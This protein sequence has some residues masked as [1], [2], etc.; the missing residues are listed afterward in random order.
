M[1]THSGWRAS[2]V[3]AAT[4]AV[5]S[6]CASTPESSSDLDRARAA[7][8]RVESMPDASTVAG[9]ELQ[10]ARQSLREAEDAFSARSRQDEVVHLSYM[11][12]RQAG[13]AEARIREA[14]ATRQTESAEAAR[15]AALLQARERET[16]V[17]QQRAAQ[18]EAVAA[19]ALQQLQ[20]AKQTE[21]G[22]VMT[23]GDVM[24]DVGAATLKPGAHLTLDRLAS[25][26]A[27]NPGTRVIVEGHTDS[28][29]G[30]AMNQALSE[31]RAS[32]VAAAL[33]SRGVDTSRLDVVGLGESFPVAT[34][35]ST[36]GRQQN[37][38]V[39]V[40]ISDQSGQFPESARR[41]ASRD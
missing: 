15:N 13:I 7:V 21:R 37:R 38:R 5:L 40:V 36:A 30:D 29:G 19:A 14:A 9:A 35:D 23:M 18:A 24:F 33:R 25:F 27:A 4:I 10:Q 12:E 1:K 11:A 8:A 32:S 22:V 28:T 17:A 6:A 39:E 31:R 26:M 3:A 16:Q 20:D 41:T 2:L 34:N